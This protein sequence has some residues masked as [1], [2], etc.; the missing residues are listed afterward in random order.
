MT[1]DELIV[2][3]KEILE[4]DDQEFTMDTNLK[5]TEGYDSL[6]VLSMIALIDKEFK[7]AVSA[8]QVVNIT[9]IQSLVDLIGTENFN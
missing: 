4:I 1:K 3:L 5:E 2:K 8:D 6:F 9:T 7:K